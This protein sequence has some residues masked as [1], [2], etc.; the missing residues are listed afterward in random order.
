MDQNDQ[1]QQQAE[2]G[3]AKEVKETKPKPTKAERLAEKIKKGLAGKTSNTASVKASLT[4]PAAEAWTLIKTE[5]DRLGMT[6][7]DLIVSLLDAGGKTL[8]DALRAVK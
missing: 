6:E 4:G 1:N 2:G 3:N 8:L 5:G 7:T